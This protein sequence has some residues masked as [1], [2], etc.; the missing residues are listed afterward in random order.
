L[1][2]QHGECFFR[3]TF[4]HFGGITSSSRPERTE[5]ETGAMIENFIQELVPRLQKLNG[6]ALL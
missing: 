6:N 1:V 5:A 2:G 4:N 3:K